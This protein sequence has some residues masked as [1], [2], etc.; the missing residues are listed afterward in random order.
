MSNKLPKAHQPIPQHM[1][2]MQSAAMQHQ[3]HL[4]T[5]DVLTKLYTASL[6]DNDQFTLQEP[7]RRALVN[8]I[9][10]FQPPAP[11]TPPSPVI[12][13]GALIY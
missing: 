1:P 8:L 4:Q 12:Q 11:V 10:P 5:L 6:A 2:D 9:E 3:L 13:D 7:L